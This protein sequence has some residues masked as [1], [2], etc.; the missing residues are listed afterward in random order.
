[1]VDSIM[2]FIKEYA[3]E[4]DSLKRLIYASNDY[5]N[6]KDDT[7]KNTT[8]IC[9]SISNFYKSEKLKYIFLE[10][11]NNYVGLK[12]KFKS[13]QNHYIYRQFFSIQ[14]KNVCEKI[15]KNIFDL[16][17]IKL[18][19][20]YFD[21]RKDDRNKMNS[22]ESYLIES[23]T[24][25]ASAIG[26]AKFAPMIAPCTFLASETFKYAYKNSPLIKKMIKG[27][28]S[29]LQLAPQ[30]LS[31]KKWVSFYTYRILEQLGI[32]TPISSRIANDLFICIP[33]THGEL[34]Q[35]ETGTYPKLQK[36]PIN[37][38]WLDWA[39]RGA[40][41]LLDNRKSCVVP[42][43]IKIKDAGK[44]LSQKYGILT[45]TLVKPPKQHK[46]IFELLIT[47]LSIV[48]LNELSNAGNNFKKVID[49]TTEGE[50]IANSYYCSV[51]G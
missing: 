18:L 27:T 30:N 51:M 32:T 15:I 42:K 44:K 22:L 17:I 21:K 12:M 1:M 26:L 49:Y 34:I 28:I 46:I 33:I 35:L 16:T 43:M 5:Y 13:K 19:E 6:G 29:T 4:L 2:N 38:S 47:Q 24:L 3:T 37:E 39:E 41:R 31:K 36:A 23:L 9:R 10:G 14:N 8:D 40:E 25:N 50:T 20:D 48:L 7:I 45:C 11:Y